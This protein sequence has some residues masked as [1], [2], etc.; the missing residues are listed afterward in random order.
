[1]AESSKLAQHFKP[2]EFDAADR[3][4]RLYMHRL[5]PVNCTLDEREQK[6]FFR[7]KYAMILSIGGKKTSS[8]IIWE[9]QRD[10]G[11]K[12][13]SARTLLAQLPVVYPDVLENARQLEKED[14]VMKLHQVIER[15]EERDT[16]YD[17]EVIGKTTRIIADIRAWG[18]EDLGIK[19]GD[20]ILPQPMWTDDPSV[21]E[22]D[23]GTDEPEDAEFEELDNDN[24]DKVIE[25]GE[26]EEN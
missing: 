23:A 16:T 6:H 4:E 1:M 24:P 20:I 5:D 26:E 14:A 9:L 2:A 17:D 15:C 18:K 21:L 19:K 13:T 8:Q 10:L 12:L 11:I 25:D 22:L 7:I 3:L